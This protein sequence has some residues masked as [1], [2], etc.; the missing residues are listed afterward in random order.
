VLGRGCGS[1]S[2]GPGT[3]PTDAGTVVDSNQ[4]PGDTSAAME[5]GAGDGPSAP[6]PTTTRTALTA[7]NTSA[8]PWFED[9]YTPATRFDGSATPVSNEDAPTSSSVTGDLSVGSVSKLPIRSLLY[10]GATTQVFVETQGWFCTNGV[11]PLPTAV[12]VD[13]CGSHVD[14][15]YATNYT[16]HAQLQVADMMSRGIDGAIMDWSGQSAG[17]GVVDTMTTSTAAINTGA[18]FLMKAAAEASAGHFRVAVMEDEGIKACAAD[19][20]CDVTTQLLSDISFLS[21]NFFSSPAYLTAGGRPVLF[22]F[23]V[24]D[25]VAAFGKT[26]DWTSVRQSAAGNPLFV[27]ENGGGFGHAESDGAY[28]WITVVPYS[29]YPGTDPFGTA[30]FLPYFYGQ[31]LAHAALSTWGSAYKGFDDNLVNGWGAGR[32]YAGQECGKTWL[33]TLA[34]TGKY[35]STSTPLDGIQLITWDD[36]EEGTELETGI[37]NHVVVTAAVQGGTLSWAVA[38]DAGAPDECTGAVAAGFDPASTIDHFTVYVSPSG[39][40]EHVAPVADSIAASTR[41]L[42]LTGR[43]PSGSWQASVYATGK[44]TIVNHLS[45]AVS[46]AL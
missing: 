29:S 19:S 27:F 34:L 11:T 20:T 43:L 46:L 38:L 23:S 40:G 25:W 31:G 35:Y 2:A 26:I 17:K 28:S 16:A 24:D 3:S 45:A 13:Q 39:D 10:P 15:G 33:D 5:S 42:D 4:G 14:I 8:S 32:R 30:S 1:P 36:Y 41:S 18:M 44:P 7:N 12:D 9:E 21:D 6:V 37:D 22:F